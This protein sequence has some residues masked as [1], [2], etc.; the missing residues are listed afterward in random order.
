MRLGDMTMCGWT[1]GVLIFSFIFGLS[2]DM[3]DL[4]MLSDLVTVHR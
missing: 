3:D 2:T 4:F 1:T